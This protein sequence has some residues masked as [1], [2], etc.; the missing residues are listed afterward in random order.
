MSSPTVRQLQT[1][2]YRRARSAAQDLTA[3]N[4][5]AIISYSRQFEKSL[6]RRFKKINREDFFAGIVDADIILYGD[7][8][9]LKQSQKGFV[10]L[11]QELA[12]FNP[13]R[14]RLIAMEAFQANQQEAL[15]LLQQQKITE[16]DFLCRIDYEKTWGFP[17]RNY[18]RI[19]SHAL[20]E[21]IPI[22]GINGSNKDKDKDKLAQR[23][24]FCAKKLTQL[25][26]QFPQHQILCITGEYH[27]ADQ[28][29]PTALSHSLQ[30]TN[31]KNKKVVRVVA[32][33]DQY[34]FSLNFPSEFTI[35][36]YLYLKK[37]LY[38]LMDTPPWVKWHSYTFWEEQ[39]SDSAQLDSRERLYNEIMIDLD[40]HVLSL[41][42]DLVKFFKFSSNPVILTLFNLV[43]GTPEK[44]I[45]QVQQQKLV[46]PYALKT[47]A[48]RLA[49]DEFFYVDKSKTI[50]LT[51]VSLNNLAEAAGQFL[52]D[53]VSRADFKKTA[54]NNFY[55]R[56]IRFAL[57]ILCS[58]IINPK[59]KLT[60]YYRYVDIAQGKERVDR[61][62]REVASEIVRFHSWM[63][64]RVENCD[65]RIMRHLSR[66]V[67]MDERVA[68]EISKAL[69]KIIGV[70][71]YRQTIKNCT[72]T[73]EIRALFQPQSPTCKP[74]H[75]VVDMYRCFLE[76]VDIKK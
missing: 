31:I 59:R 53:T 56:V 70:K 63:L 66:T 19:V 12:V 35:S 24:R 9:T 64:H 48:V 16:Q 21:K 37:N 10:R 39:R 5:S 23:D 62:Q 27:L 20:A 44:I 40:Y 6:P 55:Q 4:D 28:Q 8:H 54:I 15:D 42:S 1:K 3:G 47:V 14:P 18:Q 38:C 41:V 2:L 57:G 71:I 25:A 69:G 51:R 43:S 52:Y 11:L 32:N 75:V 72:P 74:W 45:R 22:F 49:L 60:N 36:H 46:S 73:E 58:K 68:F 50:M 61:E 30:K 26:R 76:R 33:I 29:L 65:G 7:F 67:A 34:Y 17:W 13:S